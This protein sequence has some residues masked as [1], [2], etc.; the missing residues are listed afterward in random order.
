[1]PDLRRHSP[2]RSV[3]AIRHGEATQRHIPAPMSLIKRRRPPFVVAY[4]AVLRNPRVSLGAKAVLMILKSYANTDGTHCFPSISTLMETSGCPRRTITRHLA[5]LRE[6]G[7]I[8]GEQRATKGGKM[9][10]M[11]YLLYD[12][13]HARA[14]YKPCATSGS[15]RMSDLAHGGGPKIVHL[16]EEIRQAG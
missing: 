7:L 12:E 16:T 2:G 1:M 4:K 10:S 5:E 14:A 9:S 15:R 11:T 3:S 6:S 8:Y 13:N